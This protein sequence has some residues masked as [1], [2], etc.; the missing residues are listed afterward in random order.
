MPML[1]DPCRGNN[2]HGR[3]EFYFGACKKQI[4]ALSNCLRE[5]LS[6]S[7]SLVKSYPKCSS[8]SDDPELEDTL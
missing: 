4:F 6:V 2:F 5:V 1:I 7:L 3:M 8:I